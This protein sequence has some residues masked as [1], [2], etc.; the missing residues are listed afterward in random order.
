MKVSVTGRL[1]QLS[2][3]PDTVVTGATLSVPICTW[4]ELVAS[5]LPAWSTE[6]YSMVCVAVMC[7]GAGM[8]TEP[9]V[10]QPPPST[11]YWV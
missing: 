6:R 2:S 5:R 11:W 1:C 3:A 9:P 10:T 8:V 4:H 7:G